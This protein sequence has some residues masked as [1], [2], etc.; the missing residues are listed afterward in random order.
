MG[1]E[2]EIL[3]VEYSAPKLYKRYF[4]TII[5][6]FIVA[7]VGM[8]FLALS[9]LIVSNVPSYK[10]MVSLRDTMQ[11]ESGLYTE[12]NQL[13]TLYYKDNSN[14]TTQEK[15]ES[16]SS[17]LEAFYTDSDYFSDGSYYQSYQNRKKEAAYNGELIFKEDNGSYVE[18]DFSDDVYYSFYET[19]LNNYA[20]SALSLNETYYGYTVTIFFAFVIELLVS[21][22]ISFTIAFL[23]IPLIF[24]RGHKTIGM[25]LFHLSFISV[26]A[27]NIKTKKFILRYLLVYGVGFLLD[28]VTVFVPLIVSMFMMH[29]SK[30]HQ[31]FFDYVTNTYV[32]DTL[33]KDVYLD[34]SEYLR[35][36]KMSQEASIENNDLHID[37]GL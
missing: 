37:N 11:V 18:T 12:E 16:L 15:K 25:Y 1:N 32:V 13:Y 29:L 33:K 8:L 5:D 10:N 9:S 19:E 2:E 27:I 36:Q 34:E 14:Y 28:I 35:R 17:I 7:I 30:A 24:K 31:D 20:V 23:V 4:A 26:D 21:F 6:L 3:D 22:S